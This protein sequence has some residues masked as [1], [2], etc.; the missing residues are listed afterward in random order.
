[1][2]R[3]G[4]VLSGR[5]S[6]FLAIAAQIEQGNLPAEIAVVISNRPDAEGLAAA[7]KRGLQALSLP[8]KG[9]DRE[10]YDRR[11]EAALREHQVDWVILAGYMRILS[12][13]F[14]RAFPQRIL[15]IHPSL[16]PA[17]PGLDAQHQAFAYGVK[18]AGCTVHFVD[19]QLDHGPI[20]L[21][22]AV[23]VEDGD[24]AETLAARILQQEHRI[25]SEALRRL[26]T[27]PWQIVDRRVELGE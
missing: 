26:F 18:I 5:G 13:G 16:L 21:Q 2:T 4:I 19:E 22:A 27:R 8:S 20:V 12:A 11:L 17:F 24:T 14:I 3:L 25:Y 7:R 9:L 6:N 23:A 1:M 15:N 10:E